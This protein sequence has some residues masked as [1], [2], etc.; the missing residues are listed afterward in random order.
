[1]P[2]VVMRSRLQVEYM[3]EQRYRDGD[4]DGDAVVPPLPRQNGSQICG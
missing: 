2:P 4:G 1:M 3:E